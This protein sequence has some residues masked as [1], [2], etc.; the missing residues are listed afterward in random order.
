MSITGMSAS[1]IDARAVLMDK[2][3]SERVSVLPH[4]IR[5]LVMDN[6][7]LSARYPN[8]TRPI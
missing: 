5:W 8:P 2:R 6:L 3:S 1:G 7:C 4:G